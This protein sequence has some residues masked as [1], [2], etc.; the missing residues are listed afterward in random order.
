MTIMKWLRQHWKTLVIIL[1]AALLIPLALD[2]FIFSNSYP[3]KVSNDGWAGFLGG[4]IGAI[5][6][7]FTTIIAITIEIRDNEKKRFQDEIRTI[8]PYLC[9]QEFTWV[10]RT[11][12]SIDAKLT[13]QN[14]GFHAACDISL[15]ENNQETDTQEIIY[16]KHLTLAA[17]G[18][19]EIS[20]KVD[21]TKT[22]YYKFAFYDIRGDRYTQE[23]R[24]EPTKK[25][26]VK[27][28]ASCVTLEPKLYKLKE[29]YESLTQ[30]KG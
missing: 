7:A 30:S 2:I 22:E 23:L 24:I 26:S 11:S 15:Y 3:S 14:V 13:V 28:I 8:R 19:K 18:Q 4:Y 20:V 29:D 10:S 27:G 12:T 16:F 5:I 1:V 25:G 6:G 9:I 21:L 17:N